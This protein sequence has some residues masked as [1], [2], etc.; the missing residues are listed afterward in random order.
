[1][2]AGAGRGLWGVLLMSQPCM[3][4]RRAGGRCRACAGVWPDFT[5]NARIR[6]GLLAELAVSHALCID[7][8]PALGPS[9]PTHK[10]VMH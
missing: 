5:G 7:L 1:M 10:T 9:L 4:A 8:L 2:A 3:G 6:H